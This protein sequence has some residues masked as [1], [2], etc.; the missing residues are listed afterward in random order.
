MKPDNKIYLPQTY[1]LIHTHLAQLRAVSA[2][3]KDTRPPTAV[4]TAGQW[5]MSSIVFQD[6]QTI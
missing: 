6:Q 3:F 2:D 1:T 4:N 5:E